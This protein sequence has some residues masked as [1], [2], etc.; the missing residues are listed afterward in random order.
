[1]RAANCHIRLKVAFCV[2]PPRSTQG[3]PGIIPALSRHI[4]AIRAA[5]PADVPSGIFRGDPG[6]APAAHSD[7]SQYPAPPRFHSFQF[8]RS[9]A[10]DFS[11]SPV[12]HSRSTL[13]KRPL[14]HFFQQSRLDKQRARQI[15]TAR[16][17]SDLNRWC[18]NIVMGTMERP[19]V[20]ATGARAQVCRLHFH[21]MHA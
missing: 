4:P 20:A 9:P 15:T 8:L 1:M 21:C 3:I 7:R 18:V 13:Y 6:G 14:E 12:Y 5:L 17:S 16:D 19:W 2:L 10:V 11:L